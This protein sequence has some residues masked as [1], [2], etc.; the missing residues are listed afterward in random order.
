MHTESIKPILESFPL[1]KTGEEKERF[2]VVISALNLRLVSLAKASEI[3]S[4]SRNSLLDLLD[5][6]NLEYSYLTEKDIDI[7]KAWPDEGGI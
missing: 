5:A 1:F 6:L 2:L 3:M 4:M 7:E